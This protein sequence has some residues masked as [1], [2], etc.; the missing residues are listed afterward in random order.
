LELVVK[1]HRHM[2]ETGQDYRIAFIPEPVC[3]TEAPES[4]RVLGASAAAGTGARSKSSSSIATC[5]F[6]RA[7]AGSAPSAS[8]TCCW[9]TC[10]AFVELF[11]YALIP[12]MWGLGLLDVGYLLAFLA[13]TFTFGIF[14][15]VCALI[16]EEIELKRFPKAWHLAVLTG[17]AVLENFGY[18]Q[19][20]NLWRLRG[21][22]QYLRG[23]QGWGDMRRVGFAKR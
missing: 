12:V 6:A 23:A 2:R 17:A 20:N 1:L 15:S 11:G 14:I 8:G 21:T 16:L 7:T 19:I 13:V 18:R 22:W 5:C 10:R 9:W 4:L 3:W